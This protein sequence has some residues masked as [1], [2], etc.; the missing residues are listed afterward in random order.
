MPNDPQTPRRSETAAFRL[1]PDEARRLAAAA[2]LDG[3]Y[4]ADIAR[5]GA[6]REATRILQGAA[7]TEVEPGGEAQDE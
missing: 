5:R 7:S 2:E 4:R 1:T 6:L 3:G